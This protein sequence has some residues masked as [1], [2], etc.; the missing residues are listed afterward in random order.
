MQN[1]LELELNFSIIIFVSVSQSFLIGII[2]GG[3]DYAF[4][5]YLFHAQ[6]IAIPAY[7]SCQLMASIKYGRYGD[8]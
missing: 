1:F 3:S 5:Q 8:G 2:E 7:S 6:L 4:Q